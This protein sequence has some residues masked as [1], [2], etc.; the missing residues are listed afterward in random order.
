MDADNHVD[1]QL[2]DAKDVWV[3]GA[4]VGAIKEFQ[5]P[6]DTKHTVDANE[7]EVN[8]EVQVEQVG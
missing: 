1:D 8:A 6:A 3:I 5:H 2:Q 7:R 4:R